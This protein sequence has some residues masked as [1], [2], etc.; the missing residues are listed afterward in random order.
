ME[1]KFF[2]F[3]IHEWKMKHPSET[4]KLLAFQSSKE[5]AQFFRNL[6]ENLSEEDIQALKQRYKIA[7]ERYKE[8]IR[9]F[10]E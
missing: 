4:E 2:Y 3:F 8:Q 6:Y 5:N 1:T 10:E 7:E 9:K